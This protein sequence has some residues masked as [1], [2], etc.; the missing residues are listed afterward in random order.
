[1]VTA[2]TIGELEVEDGRA[3]T[4]E[5]L[6]DPDV[7]ENEIDISDEAVAD[8]EV[9]ERPLF[10]EIELDEEEKEEE[11]EEAD[12]EDKVKDDDNDDFEVLIDEPITEPVVRT[13]KVLREFVEEGDGI[14][15]SVPAAVLVLEITVVVSEVVTAFEEV[16]AEVEMVASS[17]LVAVVVVVVIVGH[18]GLLLVLPFIPRYIAYS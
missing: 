1:M 18:T 9:V 16:E 15:E 12:E 2:D 11:K 14:F 7:G 3:G 10:G 6:G 8:A 4:L 17:V 5:L 13:L